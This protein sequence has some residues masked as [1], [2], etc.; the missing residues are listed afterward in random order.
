M[1][2]LAEEFVAKAQKIRVGDP[3]LQPVDLTEEHTEVD[4]DAVRVR[5]ADSGP[6]V[7][8]EH[9][10]AQLRTL[11]PAGAKKPMPAQQRPTISGVARS[12]QTVTSVSI[13]RYNLNAVN[14]SSWVADLTDATEV[15]SAVSQPFAT[16]RSQSPKLAAQAMPQ[17]EQMSEADR[18]RLD[19]V[20]VRLGE[21]ENPMLPENSFDRIFMVHMYHE[22]ERPSEFL[23]NLRGAHKRGASVI[24][25]KSMARG[26]SQRS[27]SLRPDS[28]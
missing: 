9:L 15:R 24:V 3:L 16:F 20:S 28:S 4:D 8:A 10:E 18:E 6:G 5:V 1:G 2:N 19:N 11:R 17:M 21:P 22:I 27:S 26:N 7:P 25:Y 14:A 12:L 13:G 23:W